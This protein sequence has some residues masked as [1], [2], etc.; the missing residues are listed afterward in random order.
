MKYQLIT[1][2]PHFDMT[3]NPIQAVVK[4]GR[5]YWIGNSRDAYY[6]ALERY[7]GKTVSL[8]IDDIE[9][10]TQSQLGIYYG[11]WLPMIRSKLIDDGFDVMGV[12]ISL[13]YTD[14]IVK[15]FCARIDGKKII[16][17]RTMSKA[18][19]SAFL[20]NVVRWAATIGVDLPSPPDKMK[21]E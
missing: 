17:K 10:K 3:H 4:D 9:P 15:N 1:K 16:L 8:T 2:N 11:V 6:V 5:L 7:Q 21:N 20:E 19:M 12:P 13:E 18:K 14:D